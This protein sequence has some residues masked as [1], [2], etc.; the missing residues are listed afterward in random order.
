MFGELVATFIYAYSVQLSK[1]RWRLAWWTWLFF[2]SIK[3]SSD[4]QFSD[5]SNDVAFDRGLLTWFHVHRVGHDFIIFTQFNSQRVWS[6][7]LWWVAYSVHVSNDAAYIRGVFTWFYVRRVGHDC[8][9]GY[10]YS[11]HVSNY[12]ATN[13]LC[14]CMSNDVECI[15]RGPCYMISCAD[16]WHDVTYHELESWLVYRVY[17]ELTS[18]MISYT[19]TW[20]HEQRV[21]Q[22]TC[23]TYSEMTCYMY[24][25]FDIL[26]DRM[27]KVGPGHDFHIHAL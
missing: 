7:L 16:I 3:W 17:S 21:G 8:H 5:M 19:E 15:L 10:E 20:C 18:Y 26:R 9:D 2:T 12:F 14:V 11:L 4:I 27:Y 6:P 22:L 25:E 13:V 23:Y 24:R 1:S